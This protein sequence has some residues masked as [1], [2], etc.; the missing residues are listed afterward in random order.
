MTV[1]EGWERTQAPPC[2]GP[3]QCAITRT[4]CLPTLTCQCAVLMYHWDWLIVPFLETVLTAMWF[5]YSPTDSQNIGSSRHCNCVWD[6]NNYN[7]MWDK[8]TKINVWEALVI[9]VTT[10]QTHTQTALPVINYW[11]GNFRQ[12]LRQELGLKTYWPYSWQ[13]PC[14]LDGKT[15][16]SR[17]TTL[18]LPE[19]DNGQTGI[20]C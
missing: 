13:N 20:A 1:V 3:T 8:K 9:T 18:I 5:F 17:T 2:P 19:K 15:F 12:F 16:L 11:A 6:R 10:T 4:V 14:G 7:D